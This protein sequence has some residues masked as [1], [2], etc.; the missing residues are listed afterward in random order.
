VNRRPLLVDLGIAVVI[1]VIVLLL[2]PGVAIV[3]L[4]AIV[5][6]LVWGVD[7]LIRRWRWHRRPPRRG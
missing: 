3:A 1:A 4:V 7:A 2:S 5:V 6:L